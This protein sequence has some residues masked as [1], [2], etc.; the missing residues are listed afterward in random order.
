[1]CTLLK[2][3]VNATNRC[4]TI[5]L[6]FHS[7]INHSLRNKQRLVLVNSKLFFWQY[8]KKHSLMEG[9]SSRYWNN[10]IWAIFMPKFMVKLVI[11]PTKNPHK[12]E[13]MQ[14]YI[15][16]KSQNIISSWSHKVYFLMTSLRIKW[17]IGGV[18]KWSEVIST[19]ENIYEHG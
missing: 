19:T 15:C 8:G 9:C 5:T 7:D 17:R 4:L 14:Y 10:I 1:M 6:K 11:N 18:L 13:K 12:R 3:I 16:Y 2:S